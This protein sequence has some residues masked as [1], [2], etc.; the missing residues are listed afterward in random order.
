MADEHVERSARLCVRE[1]PQDVFLTWR[2]RLTILCAP[3]GTTSLMRPATV[4]PRQCLRRRSAPGDAIAGN[5]VD[6][7][8]SRLNGTGNAR[9]AD[10]SFQ[11]VTEFNGRFAALLCGL[12]SPDPFSTTLS[13]ETAKYCKLN[14]ISISTTA[15]S[16]RC[17]GG[18][19]RQETWSDQAKSLL[20]S[21]ADAMDPA[22]V[23][24]ARGPLVTAQDRY[25]PSTSSLSSSSSSS[26][27]AAP[28]TPG[29]CPAE[30]MAGFGPS[31]LES[32][33]SSF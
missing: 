16:W 22:G 30:L 9:P 28:V 12:P 29:A 32:C 14:Q 25:H 18:E 8:L 27:S 7:L 11:Y 17:D 19:A 3:L 4:D 21:N 15:T 10:P 2:T 6:G 1:H 26:S 13:P 23:R 33:S 20:C 31:C 24:M 5:M